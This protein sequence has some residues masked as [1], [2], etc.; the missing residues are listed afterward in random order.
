MLALGIPYHPSQGV[1]RTLLDRT[2]LHLPADAV[3]RNPYALLD[4]DVRHKSPPFS[5]IILPHFYTSK[6]ARIPSGILALVCELLARRS[7]LFGL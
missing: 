4:Y 7:I 6:S 1:R 5:L 2:V 3:T